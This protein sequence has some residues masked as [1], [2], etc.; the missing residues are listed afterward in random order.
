[1]KNFEDWK[2]DFFKKPKIKIAFEKL[3]S[4]EKVDIDL[5]PRFKEAVMLACYNAKKYHKEGDYLSAARRV[6]HK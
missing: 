2:F 5:Y 3:Q 6:K 1:M 4:L